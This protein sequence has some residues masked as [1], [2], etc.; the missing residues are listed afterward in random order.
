MWNEHIKGYGTEDDLLTFVLYMKFGNP[1]LMNDIRVYH[2]WHEISD[3]NYVQLENNTTVFNISCIR[4]K[5]KIKF[6]K[7]NRNRL[8]NLFCFSAVLPCVIER[9]NPLLSDVF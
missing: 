8:N 6:I 3:N 5:V 7:H 4:N 1:F 2:I 9:Y